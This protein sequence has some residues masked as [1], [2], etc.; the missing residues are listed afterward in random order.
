MEPSAEA[1]HPVLGLDVY[2]D[3]K[4][5]SAIDQTI[6]S[7]RPSV[8]APFDL[9]EGGRAYLIFKAIYARAIEPPSDLASAAP[10]KTPGVTDVAT[11]VV[12]LLIYAGKFLGPGE[13]APPTA[14]LRIYLQGYQ[15]NDPLG[16]VQKT[17]ARP[18]SKWERAVFP[19]LIFSRMLSNASQPFVFETRRQL[20]IDVLRPLPTG[21]TLVG[22]L[23]ILLLAFTAYGD[24]IAAR[25]AVRDARRRLFGEKEQA[26]VTLQ[27]IADAVITLDSKG[28]V[29]LS[30]TRLLANLSRRSLTSNSI[31]RMRRRRV[32]LKEH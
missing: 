16:L 27:A 28:R 18:K 10:R 24:K 14:S 13:L 21:L 1:V 26:L 15:R 20:G 30:I 12:S 32:H 22:T 6:A 9:F 8:S 17:S 3:S 19:E 5:K 31:L 25:A 29:Q 11:R 23:L 7:G 4:F 2:A